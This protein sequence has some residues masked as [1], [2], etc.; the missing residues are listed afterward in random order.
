TFQRSNL[1]T[2]ERSTLWALRDVSFAVAHGEAVGVIG[3]NGAG[4]TTLLKILARITGPTT[5]TAEL[6]GRVGSLLGIDTGFHAELTGR[7]NIYLSGAILGMKR[8]E[9]ARKFDAIVAFAE[10]DAFV[11]TPVKHYS[12]GMYVR[13]A[14]AVS[15]HL[16]PDILLV[17]EVLAVGDAAFQKKCLGKM[18]DVAKQGRTVLFVSHNL[19]AI[20]TLCPR[21]IVLKDGRLWADGAHGVIASYLD[22]LFADAARDLSQ[23]SDTADKEIWFTGIAFADATGRALTAA[24]TGQDLAVRVSYDGRGHTGRPDCIIRI[25][26]RLDQPLIF[27]DSYYSWRESGTVWP[28]RGVVTCTIPKLPLPVG[29]YRV[30]LTLRA[31]GR[32]ADQVSDAARLSVAEGDF[33]GTGKL[34]PPS[35][36]PLLVAHEWDVSAAT[37]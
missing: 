7:E 19:A 27:C 9:V 15:A 10:L 22:S 4:K 8:R 36:A 12:S 5:G 33:Y 30:A 34:P 25:M 32:Y 26:D 1:S 14:F 35:S 11:D 16:E 23:R 21:V 2:F 17:D 29:E 31:N 24:T 28:Q 6:Q 13:L 20:A 18:D 3:H 37:N